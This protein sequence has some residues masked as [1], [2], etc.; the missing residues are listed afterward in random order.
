MKKK[1]SNLFGAENVSDKETD[2]E[3]YTYCASDKIQ[4]PSLIVWPRSTEDVRKTILR[5]NQTRNPLIIRGKGTSKTNSCTGEDRIIISSERLNKI[6]RI[7]L[8]K[9]FVELEPGVTLA[10]LNQKLQRINRALPLT[11]LSHAQSV[12]G[13]IALNTPGIE[14]LRMG[15][16]QDLVEELEFVDGTGKQYAVKDK[17]KMMPITEGMA[18]FITRAR[19]KISEPPTLSCDLLC[20]ENISDMLK[21]VRALTKNIETYFLKFIDKKTSYD[22]GFGNNYTIIAAYTSL[23]GA[24][25][26]REEVIKIIKKARSIH[27]KIRERGYYYVLDPRVSLEKTYDLISWCEEKNLRLQGDVGTGN[28][29]AYIHKQDQKLLPVF[30]SFIRRINGRLGTA[31]GYG[32]LNKDFV[33]PVK[34]KKL[35]KIKEEYDYNNTLNPGIIISYR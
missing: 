19:M 5:A 26:K 34:K 7:N 24:T 20:F 16:A 2:L 10:E 30:R 11:P 29:Y 33:N 9:N 23:I 18:G 6:T 28:F 27:K 32:R 14:S 4:K 22:L 31:F 21:K 17:D 13:M 12:G 1:L 25:R 35:M 3:A 15:K 8:Q